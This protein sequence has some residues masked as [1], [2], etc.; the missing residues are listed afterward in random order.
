MIALSLLCASVVLA[1]LWKAKAGLYLSSSLFAFTFNGVI[2]LIAVMFG[3]RVPTARMDRFFGVATLVH[4]LAQAIGVAIAG[5][6]KDL[7]ATFVVPFIV[8]ALVIALCP[9]VLMFMKEK[10]GGGAPARGQ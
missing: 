3:D 6:L 8:S 1:I 10:R 9:A 4:A 2:T 7:T 5:W